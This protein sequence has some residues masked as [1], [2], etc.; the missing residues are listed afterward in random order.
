MSHN[1]SWKAKV[2]TTNQK[3]LTVG[4]TLAAVHPFCL[5]ILLY[6]LTPTLDFFLRTRLPSRTTTRVNTPLPYTFDRASRVC[7]GPSK[8]SSDVRLQLFER[9]GGDPDLLPLV[10]AH[11][12]PAC[13]NA[14]KGLLIIRN[15]RIFTTITTSRPW[16]RSWKAFLRLCQFVNPSI[17]SRMSRH[18]GQ[19]LICPL[20]TPTG[21]SYLS[22][23]LRRILPLLTMSRLW[24]LGTAPPPLSILFRIRHRSN[25]SNLYPRLWLLVRPIHK[26]RLHSLI[27]FIQSISNIQKMATR[28][29]PL[30]HNSLLPSR[31]LCQAPPPLRVMML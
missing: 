24:T 17:P 23:I 26:V 21:I 22:I 4:P 18:S 8:K 16:Y 10:P 7:K 29:L 9:R 19:N 2:R 5:W 1:E 6:G 30:F 11:S 28:N 25:T 20:W 15:G 31:L 3:K 12:T 27:S 13:R 14:F